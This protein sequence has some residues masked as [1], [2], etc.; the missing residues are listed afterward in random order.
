MLPAT[1]LKVALFMLASASTGFARLHR[2]DSA[3]S[4][5][6]IQARDEPMHVRAFVAGYLYGRE[7]ADESITA[8]ELDEAMEGLERRMSIGA[9]LTLVLI[10]GSLLN[11]VYHSQVK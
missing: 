1:I 11:L 4:N 3:E 9:Q 6:D 5:V 7:S 8:R 10:L 2:R